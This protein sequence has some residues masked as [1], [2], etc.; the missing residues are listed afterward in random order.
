MTRQAAI[1]KLSALVDA[2]EAPPLTEADLE[3]C[4]DEAAGWG[5]W[6]A[7]TAFSVGQTIAPTVANGRLYRCAESGTTDA[8]EPTWPTERNSYSGRR[9][10]DGTAVWVDTGPAPTERYDMKAAQRAAWMLRATRTA[11]L[12]DVAN[13]QDK[14]TLSQRHE[15]CLAMARRFR[16]FYAV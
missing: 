16:S 15:Q 7:A 12:I 2:G 6:V 3:S 8:T 5:L 1:Q 11:K 13:G 4:V 9:I 10:S 14:L